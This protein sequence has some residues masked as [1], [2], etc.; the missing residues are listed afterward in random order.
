MSFKKILLSLMAFGLMFV[1]SGCYNL[2]AQLVISA[3]DDTV[4][5]TMTF[6]FPK[7]YGEEYQN[8]LPKLGEMPPGVTLATYDNG[9]DPDS[10]G[11]K[12]TTYTLDRVKF[13]DLAKQDS[14]GRKLPFT[15]SKDEEGTY[16]LNGDFSKWFPDKADIQ[17]MG[18]TPPKPLQKPTIVLDFTFPYNVSKAPTGLEVTGPKVKIE[19]KWLEL[20]R[21]F[22]VKAAATSAGV[23]VSGFKDLPSRPASDTSA[24]PLATQPRSSLPDYFFGALLFLGIAGILFGHLTS[25]SRGFEN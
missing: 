25:R 9:E 23:D 12:G 24:Y 20:N 22:V 18:L 21:Q 1:L 19:R 15:V 7:S 6:A 3:D 17:A 11:M 16:V 10:G 13:A 5:G 2:N 4:S 14:R 8:L